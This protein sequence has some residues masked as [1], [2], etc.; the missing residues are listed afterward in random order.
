MI[1]YTHI[2]APEE[3]QSTNDYDSHRELIYF[4]LKYIGGTFIEVGCGYGSTL[5]LQ[6]AE[7]E[8]TIK[9]FSFDND[10]LWASKFNNVSVLVDLINLTSILKDDGMKRLFGDIDILFIDSK[11]GEQRKE[12]IEKFA[13]HAKVIIVHDTEE[14]ANY[15]YGMKDILNS[16]KF[17]INYTPEGKPHTTAVSNFI[18]IEEWK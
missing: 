16:F 15:V 9:L 12:L 11:P 8:K 2:E 4:I 17:R 3:W 5:L 6:K 10:K 14:T 13:N 18:N 7:R 1:E